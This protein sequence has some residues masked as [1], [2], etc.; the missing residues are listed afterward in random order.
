MKADMPGKDTHMEYR[1]S[2]D[3]CEPENET[4][5]K[6]AETSLIFLGSEWG[7]PPTCLLNLK[8]AVYKPEVFAMLEAGLPQ[9]AQAVASFNILAFY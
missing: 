6:C 9:A 3:L 7:P 1:M 4:I 5:C 8:K 2:E